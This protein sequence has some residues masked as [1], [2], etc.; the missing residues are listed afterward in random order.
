VDRDGPRRRH[1]L[2]RPGWGAGADRHRPLNAS[3]LTWKLGED[4]CTTD[5]FLEDDDG[6]LWWYGRRGSWRASGHGKQPR[7]VPI[8]DH[9]AAFGDRTIT[10]SAAITATAFRAAPTPAPAHGW[11]Q[12]DRAC[13]V[14]EVNA[15]HVPHVID[16]RTIVRETRRVNTGVRVAVA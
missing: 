2:P 9:Q 7:E 12:H 15:L 8:V 10:L 16:R 13:G 4:D 11:V 1:R 6:T 5:Y 14:I 3:A